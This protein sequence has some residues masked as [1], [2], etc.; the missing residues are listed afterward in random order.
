MM[1]SSIV[2]L[3]Q[4]NG[5]LSETKTDWCTYHASFPRN[6]VNSGH[7]SFTET[8]WYWC[9]TTFLRNIRHIG[10]ALLT[11]TDEHR[12]HVVFIMIDT[13]ATPLSLWLTDVEAS[14]IISIVFRPHLKIVFIEGAI[15][16]CSWVELS[17]PW[18]EVQ[19]VCSIAWILKSF[20]ALQWHFLPF[21]FQL[22]KHDAGK[23]C[24]KI[25]GR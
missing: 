17:H 9:H 18:Q 10:Y 1:G 3:L 16:C 25:L 2:Y 8:D 5:I 22:M 11:G 7:A 23:M 24:L 20:E 15:F 4:K 21:C 19:F 6:N 12:G 14:F 13:E